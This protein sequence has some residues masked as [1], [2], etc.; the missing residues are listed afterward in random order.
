MNVLSW[1]CRGM[2]LPLKVQFLVDVIRQE[3]HE[4]VFLYETMAKKSR[5]E[6][7]KNKLGFEGLITV[8]PI[9][10]SGGLALMWKE[11]EQVEVRNFLK[12]HIDV[13]IS[14]ADRYEWRLTCFYG[15]PDRA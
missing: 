10:Q 11:K 12:N 4:I 6:W 7:I 14:E 8:D 5:M 1:N 2:G 13:K 3:Q 15:E 9:G